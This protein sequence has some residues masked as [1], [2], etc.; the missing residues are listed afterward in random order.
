MEELQEWIK[1]VISL[2]LLGKIKIMV[3]LYDKTENGIMSFCKEAVWADSGHLETM[4]VAL[5]LLYIW[6]DRV[7]ILGI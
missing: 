4:D 5:G 1:L 2:T 7:E 3:G 6:E